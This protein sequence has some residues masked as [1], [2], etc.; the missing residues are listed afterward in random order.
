M[1]AWLPLK[2][3]NLQTHKIWENSKKISGKNYEQEQINGLRTS[4]KHQL[5]YPRAYSFH[6]K[7]QARYLTRWIYRNFSSKHFIMHGHSRAV[8]CTGTSALYPKASSGVIISIKSWWKTVQSL[9]LLPGVT[10]QKQDFPL[11]C[12]RRR[13]M[14][15]CLWTPLS[16][17]Q[18]GT[19]EDNIAYQ[20]S[21]S[22]HNA[23]GDKWKGKACHRRDEWSQELFLALMKT[24]YN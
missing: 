7:I 23:P 2:K 9:S 18:R 14:K 13:R 3:Q 8:H 21:S 10:G 16:T 5:N 22:L 6:A 11:S 15:E 20:S 12:G 4:T 24:C 1:K 19:D 17:P